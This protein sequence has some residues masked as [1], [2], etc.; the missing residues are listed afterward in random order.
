V[1]CPFLQGCQPKRFVFL[2][3]Y[4]YVCIMHEG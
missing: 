3:G 2:T 1:S 4:L